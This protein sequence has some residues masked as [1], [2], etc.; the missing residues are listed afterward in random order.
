[1]RDAIDS[2]TISGARLLGWGDQFASL[3]VGKSADFVILDRDILALADR[4]DP[5][6]IEKTAVIETYFLGRSV[7]RIKAPRPSPKS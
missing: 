7:Y 5:E 4:G 3:E 6:S 2:Y 1:V